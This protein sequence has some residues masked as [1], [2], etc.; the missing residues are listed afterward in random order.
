[1]PRTEEVAQ[2]S[3]LG[4]AGKGGSKK[5]AKTVVEEPKKR[6][7]GRSNSRRKEKTEKGGGEE[8]GG[9]GGGAE[10]G[11]EAAVVTPPQQDIRSF[12]CSAAIAQV[13]EGLWASA[14]SGTRMG[15]SLEAALLEKGVTAVL[16]TLEKATKTETFEQHNFD[17]AEGVRAI[18]D[19]SDFI[20]EA[21]SEGGAVFVHSKAG[22]ARSDP[23]LLVCLGYA[24]KYQNTKLSDAL[25][26]LSEAAKHPVSPAGDARRDLVAFEEDVLGETTVPEHW[27]AADDHGPGGAKNHSLSR[28]KLAEN[29]NDRRLLKKK[30]PHK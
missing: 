26:Q 14:V 5:Q 4:K 29:L 16:S 3:S 19:A 22:F 23:A 24:I 9:G 10:G 15:S 27:V 20:N 18:H 2:S 6:R 21:V 13:G 17:P 12:D 1:M 30:S 28:R 8:F 11:E 7:G 25:D